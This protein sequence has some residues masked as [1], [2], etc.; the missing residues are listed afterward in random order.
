MEEHHLITPRTARYH[1]VGD[2]AS[3]KHIWIVLHGYGQLARYFLRPFEDLGTDKLITA[4]EGLSR[5]YSDAAHK[6]VGATWMTR[7]DRDHEIVDQA[8]YLDRLAEHLQQQCAPGTPLSV[9]GFSQGVATACRWALST[10]VAIQRLVLWGGTIPPEPDAAALHEKLGGIKVVLVHGEQ[11][12]L[13]P[14]EVF[15][16]NGS[17]LHEAGLEHRTVRFAGGH[18][19]ERIALHRALESFG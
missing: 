15:L 7:E 14:E 6:R 9:L 2:A 1:T 19:L 3:A 10:N 11:D 18:E 12:K 16:Q 5:F 8:A 4:P 17:R 13:V